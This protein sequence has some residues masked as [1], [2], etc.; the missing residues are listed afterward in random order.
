[1]GTQTIRQVFLQRFLFL[2]NFHKCFYN[3]KETQTTFYLV[4]LD[5]TATEKEKELVYFDHQNVKIKLVLLAPSLSQQLVL[6]LCN[7]LQL[8]YFLWAIL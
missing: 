1:M 6:V 3:S 5:N 2:P 4:L 7:Q 8:M